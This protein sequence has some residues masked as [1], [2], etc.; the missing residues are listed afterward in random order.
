MAQWGV[1]SRAR[2]LG[3]G[4]GLALVP[5]FAP[6][7][8]GP[9]TDPPAPS[10]STAAPPAEVTIT[11]AGTS[12]LHGRL[13]TLPLFASYARAL[14]SGNRDGVVLVDAGDMFQ[15]TLES[16]QNEG[17]AVVDAY[18]RIGYDAVTIGNHEFDY[19]PVG[20]ASVV[21]KSAP[22][23]PERDPRGA[24]KARAAQARGA[25]PFLAAN[26]LEDDKPF[27]YPNVVPF[28]IVERHG[29]KIGIVGVTSADTTSTTIAANGVGVRVVPLVKAI[30]DQAKA[31]RDQGAKVV[32][33][34]A[35]AGGQCTRQDD[36]KDLSSCDQGA[37]IVEVAKGL[38]EGAVQAIVAGHTHQAIA[39][40]V[41][42]IPIVQSRANGEAFGR[43]DLTVDPQTGKVL[44]TKIHPPQPVK[45]GV[46]YEGVAVEPAADVREVVQPALDRANARRA[47][48]LGVDLKGPF[49]ARY[50]EECALGN[51]LTSL[52]LELDPKM[53]V[54]LLNGGGLRA[55]LPPGVLTFGALYDALPF[56]NRLAR[57][58]MTGRALRE[59]FA[60]NLSGK[61]GILSIAGAKVTGRCEGDRLAVDIVLA[62]SGK[63]ERTLR[64]QDQ[65]H[66]L[67]N[68]FLATLGDGFAPAE[69]V[70]LDEEGPPFRDP[71]AAAFK[72]RG[73]QMAPDAWL[74]P[75]KPRIAL[76]GPIGASVC[77]RRGQ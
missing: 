52:L 66:V 28:T 8:G 3:F 57:L 34:A 9:K 12:D 48:S 68:E 19:G 35:H 25:F 16:N 44:R 77:Q 55:D 15:G 23:G 75:G 2:A 27:S 11:V 72:K 65:V 6:A 47:E 4:V 29:V 54:A 71:L 40:E 32:I 61:G 67:T 49:P 51:L 21:R 41:A 69:K 1:S 42:G 45:P 53:D 74:L 62:R 60:K 46:T 22:E 56:D 70:E 14:K 59:V 58:T 50:R 24:L 37:E 20:E 26:L 31:A 39:H 33:V 38:P 5:L 64:D 63:A 76:P 43:I 18:K 13:S 36:P 17:A 7:C 30:R 10:T 73:G